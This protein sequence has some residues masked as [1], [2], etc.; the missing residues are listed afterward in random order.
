MSTVAPPP[1]WV[2]A[3]DLLDQLGGIAP[4]RLR[5]RPAPGTATEQDLLDMDA[6]DKCMCELVDGVLVEKVMGY[7]ESALAVWLGHLLQRYLLETNDLGVLSGESGLTRLMPGLVRIP[8][9]SFIRWDRFPG[10]KIPAE[11]ILG[12]APDLVVEVLSPANTSGEMKRKLREYFLAGVRLVWL[13]DPRKRLVK[14]Y[15]A[16]D[17]SVR[18][19]EPDT[20]D[21]GEVLPGLQL[22]VRRIF[23]RLEEKPR[24]KKPPRA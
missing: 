19:T 15:T 2:T 9:L 16:P 6:R 20:L 12:L 3:A 22:P 13:V 4:D 10:G 23:E 24:R 8:D 5:L 18:L 14:V 17:E 1:E 21:G 11:A 7:P